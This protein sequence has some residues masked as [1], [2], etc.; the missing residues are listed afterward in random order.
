MTR[1]L[2]SRPL[3]LAPTLVLL[4]GSF[5]AAAAATPDA[6]TTSDNVRVPVEGTVTDCAGNPVTITG[7][8]HVVTHTTISAS[9]HYVTVYHIDQNLQGVSADGTLHVMNQQLQE[10]RTGDLSDGFPFTQTFEIHSNLNNNDPNVPQLHIWALL[11]VTFNE[12]GELTGV[13]SELKEE[14]QG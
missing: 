5:M 9:G 2:F 14:C 6:Q 11:H 10:T 4:I 1:K 13:Q 3:L 8:V 12:N 7:E